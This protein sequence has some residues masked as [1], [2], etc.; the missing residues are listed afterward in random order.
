MPGPTYAY[1]KL[2]QG[3]GSCDGLKSLLGREIESKGIS[4]AL[5]KRVL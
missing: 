4:S 1:L 5:S 3:L 2:I